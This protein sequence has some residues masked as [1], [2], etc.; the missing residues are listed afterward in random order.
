[1]FKIY[2][3]ENMLSGKVSSDTRTILLFNIYLT[4]TLYKMKDTENKK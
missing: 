1:M 2:L 4:N 3:Y